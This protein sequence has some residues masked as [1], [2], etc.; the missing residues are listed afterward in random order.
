MYYNKFQTNEQTYQKMQNLH[1]Y[2][3]HTTIQ[4]DICDNN[5][6]K[7]VKFLFFTKI[8]RKLLKF[9]TKC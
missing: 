8:N 3:I 5:K 9:S 4:N 7:Y 6:I 2:N 1:N